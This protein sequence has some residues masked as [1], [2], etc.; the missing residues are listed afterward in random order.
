MVLVLAALGSAALLTQTVMFINKIK[1]GLRESRIA[2][3]S[4]AAGDLTRPLPAPSKDELGDLNAALSVMRNNLHE[5]IASVSEG[6]TT[7]NQ[8]SGTVYISANKSSKVSEMQS[9]AAAGMATAMEELSV[10]I[11]QVSEHAKDAHRVSQISSEKAIE[12]GKV[13]HSVATEMEHIATSV[14]QAAEKIHGLEEHS[15]QISGIANAIHEIADQT[16]LLALNAAIEAARAGEQGRGFAVVADEVRKLAE[17]TA[18]S[19]KEI[20][21]T[22]SKIQDG[23][24]ETVK[25]MEVSV[26]M[27][28]EG[29]KLARQ[30]GDSV[31]SIREAAELAA[32]DVDDITHAIQEQSLAARD[33]A[34]RI[35]KIAQGT[36][37]NTL[38]STQT[39]ES[40]KQMTEL[41]RKLDELASR[42]KIA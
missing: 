5:L 39:A 37:E 26:T 41:S 20:S 40:T 11:D 15:K 18:N 21:G 16:N 4:I 9:E 2:A 42:F 38:S 19:T 10:S 28:K 29:V 24:K 36:E 14:N 32:S 30:A 3:K 17:R 1:H 33:I 22:I 6:I 31:S 13:I 8:T 23:T 12:G 34:Q 27:V 35:E 7:L 25:E